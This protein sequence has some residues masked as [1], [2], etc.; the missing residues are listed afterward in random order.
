MKSLTIM[1]KWVISF[2]KKDWTFEDYPVKTWRN[3]NARQPNIAYGAGIV[4]WAMMVGH[5]DTPEKA[6]HELK[7]KFNNYKNKYAVPRPGTNVPIKFASTEH[8]EKYEAIA[9]DFFQRVLHINYYEGFY[10]DGSCLTYFE[11]PSDPEKAVEFRQRTIAATLLIYGVDITSTYDAP[12]YKILE[13]IANH[14]A[15]SKKGKYD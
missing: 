7:E 12:L 10:S 5:G 6:I 2:F 13:Q 3:P 1:L 4:H 15:V 9:L 11:P 8:I 14:Q